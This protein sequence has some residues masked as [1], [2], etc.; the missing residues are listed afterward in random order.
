MKKGNFTQSVTSFKNKSSNIQPVIIETDLVDSLIG[1][2]KDKAPTVAAVN[3]GL[4]GKV[5]AQS[6]SSGKNRLYCAK[7][8]NPNSYYEIDSKPWLDCIPVYTNVESNIT[9]NSSI[10]GQAT[11]VVAGPKYPFQSANKRYV[12]EEITKASGI[13][14]MSIEVVGNGFNGVSVSAGTLPHFYLVSNSFEY[15]TDGNGGGLKSANYSILTFY[16]ESDNSLG[17]VQ[18]TPNTFYEM[19][20]GTVRIMTD[21]YEIAESMGDWDIFVIK[22]SPITFMV[23]VGV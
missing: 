21:A 8:N 22:V 2:E 7:A 10:F 15:S 1:D 16:D 23:K 9:P 11:I 19:P 14:V 18:A 5:K 6:F 20:S 4:D 12:D 3:E 17:S 13:A